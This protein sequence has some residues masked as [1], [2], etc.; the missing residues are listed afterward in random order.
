MKE[1]YQLLQYRSF[2]AQEKLQQKK[3][4]Y[5]VSDLDAAEDLQS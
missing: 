4:A 5:F 3:S 1:R 2:G